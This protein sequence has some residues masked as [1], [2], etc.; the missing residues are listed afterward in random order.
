MDSDHLVHNILPEVSQVSLL[1]SVCSTDS[2][3][4]H[5]FFCHLSD[6]QLLLGIK[7]T[8]DIVVAATLKALACL[9]PI[10]GG[11]TV[12]GGTRLKLFTNGMPKV[13]RNNNM[14]Q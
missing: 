11:S 6:S 7:D 9:V 3:P 4:S 10:L 1:V 14:F 5:V 12:I 2:N 13:Q 8:D